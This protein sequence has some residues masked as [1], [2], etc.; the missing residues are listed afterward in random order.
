[1]KSQKL[2]NKLLIGK[3][4][5]DKLLYVVNDARRRRPGVTQTKYDTGINAEGFF[6]PTPQDCLYGQT[7]RDPRLSEG[8]SCKT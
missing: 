8:H 5:M 2:R 6:P 4:K 3:K 7:K 1:M